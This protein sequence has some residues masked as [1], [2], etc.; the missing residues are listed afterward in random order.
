MWEQKNTPNQLTSTYFT[1][2]P[3]AH[4]YTLSQ[5]QFTP[6]RPAINSPWAYSVIV[7]ENR[8]PSGSANHT[9]EKRGRWGRILRKVEADFIP[10]QAAQPAPDYN[11]IFPAGPLPHPAPLNMEQTGSQSQNGSLSHL[12]TELRLVWIDFLRLYRLSGENHTMRKLYYCVGGLACNRAK[13]KFLQICLTDLRIT[14][15]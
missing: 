10:D 4:T 12:M 15:S 7:P 1:Y 11:T 5:P 3:K 13:K 6:L 2:S 8:L 14:L 9:S